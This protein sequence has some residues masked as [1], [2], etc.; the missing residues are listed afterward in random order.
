MV[1]TRSAAKI[2]N[3][4]PVDDDG[5]GVLQTQ[6]DTVKPPADDGALPP[7]KKRR[8]EGEQ[9]PKKSRRRKSGN[10][11]QLN[12]DVLYV[13]FA[14]M[15]PLNLLNLARTCKSF[16]GIL[17]VK[18]SAFVWKAALRQVD[19]LPDCPDDSSEPA[20]TNLV[21]HARCHVCAGSPDAS[22]YS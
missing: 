16:R 7:A 22:N 5:N 14:S 12:L 8:R 13:I 9:A 2:I 19:G 3:P 21:F 10:I 18:S 15:R 11:F 20:Y 17:M 4:G 1:Q 6:N